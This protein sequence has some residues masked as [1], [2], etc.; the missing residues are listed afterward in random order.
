M[1]QDYNLTQ[2]VDFT[3][4]LIQD[5]R[6]GIVPGQKD[7]IVRRYHELREDKSFKYHQR[8]EPTDAMR[9]VEK[10]LQ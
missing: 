8:Y 2:W 3:F 9:R 10:K 6:F 4:R 1:I 5:R 7:I